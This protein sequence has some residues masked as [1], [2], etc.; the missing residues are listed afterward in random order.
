MFSI[1]APFVAQAAEIA[2][3]ERLE[4]QKWRNIL[5]MDDRPYERKRYSKHSRPFGHFW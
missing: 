1:I 5:A 4:Q 3:A 2:A